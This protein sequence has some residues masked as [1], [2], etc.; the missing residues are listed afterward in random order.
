[1]VCGQVNTLKSGMYGVVQGI[2][3][4]IMVLETHLEWSRTIDWMLDCSL[5]EINAEVEK[6]LKLVVT[7]HIIGPTHFFIMGEAVQISITECLKK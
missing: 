4:W 7:M 5:A 1:M 2:K 6:Q 3:R